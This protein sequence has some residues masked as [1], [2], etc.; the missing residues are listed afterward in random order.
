MVQIIKKIR[1]TECSFNKGTNQLSFVVKEFTYTPKIVRLRVFLQL[2]R[3]NKP[4]WR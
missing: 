3:G 1:L 4:Y 2:F